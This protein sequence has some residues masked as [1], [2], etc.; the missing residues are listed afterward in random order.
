MSTEKK[1][2]R[3]KKMKK[4]MSLQETTDEGATAYPKAK[5][6]RHSTIGQ[7][8]KYSPPV[9]I[10]NESTSTTSKTNSTKAEPSKKSSSML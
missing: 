2:D 9:I 4:E 8:Q 7:T 5:L 6:K 1:K 3:R 10:K